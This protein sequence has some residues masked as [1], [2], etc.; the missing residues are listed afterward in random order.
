[1]KLKINFTLKTGA[2]GEIPVLAIMN[3]GYKEFDALKQT[4][5]YKPLR[6]YTGVKVNKSEWD[7]E[8]KLPKDK[9][10]RAMLGQLEKQATDIFNYLITTETVT[11]ERLKQELDVK[12]KKK[13]DRATV[14]RV[15]IV[16]FINDYVLNDSSIKKKTKDN[17]ST[18]RNRLIEFETKIGKQLYS[19][20]IDL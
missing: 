7:L 9:T 14:T 16:E 4:F 12:I 13:D 5:V 17:Y 18:L 15:R 11:P 20:E 1:M 6:Y 19:N 8:Q 10:K 3:F 2:E